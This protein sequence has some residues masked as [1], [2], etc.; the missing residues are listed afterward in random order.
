MYIRPV[1]LLFIIWYQR[2]SL[3]VIGSY[4]LMKIQLVRTKKKK[5]LFSHI[6]VERE[7]SELQSSS[8]RDGDKDP[9]FGLRTFLTCD[10]FFGEVMKWGRL[11]I[12]RCHFLCG[13]GNRTVCASL[14]DSFRD[15]ARYFILFTA[16]WSEAFLS[17]ER[18]YKTEDIEK[19]LRH[20]RRF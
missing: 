11:E 12:L 17:I 1:S 7:R 6:T 10:F 4:L 13:N 8:R 19:Y 20:Y 9:S 18:R 16:K 15:N 14:S 2:I 3:S 5:L